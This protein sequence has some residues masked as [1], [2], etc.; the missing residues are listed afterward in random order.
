MKIAIGITDNNRSEIARKKKKMKS[1]KNLG[2]WM[3]H[4]TAKLIDI[5]GIENNHVIN[6]N[7]TFNTK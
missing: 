2:I 4:S 7:F 5:N 6:S 3:D 1:N